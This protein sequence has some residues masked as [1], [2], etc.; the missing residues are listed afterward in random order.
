MTPAWTQLFHPSGGGIAVAVI[1]RCH[2]FVVVAAQS[3]LIDAAVGE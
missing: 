1:E 3:G 2:G